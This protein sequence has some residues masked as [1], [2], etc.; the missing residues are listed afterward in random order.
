MLK[1]PKVCRDFGFI[2]D[3]N[4]SY[5]EV[6]KT[7]K[8]S[9][10]KLLKKVNLFDIFESES[11]GSDKKSLAFQLEYFDNDRT[12]REDEIDKEFWKTIETVKTKLN[13]ELRG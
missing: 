10:S 9:S 6:V 2:L 7:I 4:I 12:L 8:D 13:A 11:I 1:Y 5:N 3:K